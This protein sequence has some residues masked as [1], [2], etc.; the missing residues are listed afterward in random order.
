MSRAKRDKKI[1]DKRLLVQGIFLV[2]FYRAN[3][4]NET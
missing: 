3:A 4:R 2:S 1:P